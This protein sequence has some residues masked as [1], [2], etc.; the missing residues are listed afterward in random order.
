LEQAAQGGGGQPTCGD[1]NYFPPHK[2]HEHQGFRNTPF[3]F[4]ID[5]ASPRQWGKQKAVNKRQE[6][7]SIISIIKHA[8]VARKHKT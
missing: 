7:T 6:E 8:A 1:K 3:G 5:L 4:W 2:I